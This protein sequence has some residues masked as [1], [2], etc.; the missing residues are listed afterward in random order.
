MSLQSCGKFNPIVLLPKAEMKGSARG[1]RHDDDAPNRRVIMFFF[2]PG[3]TVDPNAWPCPKAKESNAACAPM[4][5]PDGDARRQNGDELREYRTTRDTMACRFY[6]RFARRSP[7]ERGLASFSIRVYDMAG[8]SI[9]DAPFEATIGSRKPA[10][11]TASSEG[12]VTLHDIVVPS[13]VSLRWGFKPES[14]HQPDLVFGLEMFLTHEGL[15][16]DEEA[17][18]KLN[19]LGYPKENDLAESVKEF[20]LDYGHLVDPPLPVDGSLDLDPRTFPLLQD[21]YEDCAPD[22]RNTKPT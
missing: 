22:I 4:F 7:C 16:R 2:Q 14:G 15:A 19:N 17:R 20:Q 21:V 5:W 12:I 11:G 1:T 10:K 6:E 9:A 13:Q 3:N 18:Q 8:T